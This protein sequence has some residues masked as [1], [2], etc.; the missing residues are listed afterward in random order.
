MALAPLL[1]VIFITSY[2]GNYLRLFVDSRKKKISLQTSQLRSC[3]FL[4]QQV[5][6]SARMMMGPAVWL[7]DDDDYDEESCAGTGISY[8]SRHVM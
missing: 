7:D 5:S 3:L 2:G 4:Q 1:Q 6:Q 8:Q